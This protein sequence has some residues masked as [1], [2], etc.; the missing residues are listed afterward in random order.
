MKTSLLFSPWA[1]R[2]RAAGFTLIELMI[3]VAIVGILA[4]IAYPGYRNYVIR[5]QLVDATNG[6]AAMQADMERYYQDNRTYIATGGFTPPCQ[7]VPAPIYGSFTVSCPAA[8]SNSPGTPFTGATLSPTNFQLEAVGSG[9]TNGF[10]FFI[11]QL[12]DKA[13][14][15]TAAVPSGWATCTTG[16]ETKAG[17]C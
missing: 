9:N 15:V 4:A 5:G 6:L 11:D 1:C 8:L 3:T 16:W 7:V 17:Q 14:T 10:S 2:R 12:G 13:S